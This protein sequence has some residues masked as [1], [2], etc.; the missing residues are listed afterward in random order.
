MTFVA[1][2]WRGQETEHSI[3]R[4][5]SNLD[6]HPLTPQLDGLYNHSLSSF[7]LTRK[8]RPY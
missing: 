8:I 4:V 7:W 6:A 5:K 2:K 1:T 3:S